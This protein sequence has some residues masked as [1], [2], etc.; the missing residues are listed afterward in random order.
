MKGTATATIFVLASFSARAQ[1]PD[2]LTYA[3]PALLVEATRATET[4]ANAPRSV[5][6]LYRAQPSLEPG[7]SLQHALRTLPGVWLRDRG[8]YALGERLVIRGMGYRAAFGVRGVQ[9]VMDGIPLTMADGQSTLDAADPAFIRRAELL[10]GPSSVYWGNGSGGVLF[11]DTAPASV[12]TRVRVMG[13]SYGLRH[14]SAST[15]VQMGLH[16]LVA[17]GSRVQTSGYREHSVSSFAR[18]GMQGLFSLGNRATLRLV[19]TAAILDAE[20]P[21]ALT[22]DQAHSDPRQADPRFVAASAGKES[23]HVQGG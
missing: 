20:S 7:L 19:T 22:T 1:S 12:E 16:R 5:T 23:A 13:G 2:T 9:V 11:L 21:G 3:L 18:A 15:G 17:Y 6:V 8:H 10:R 4:Q 14:V